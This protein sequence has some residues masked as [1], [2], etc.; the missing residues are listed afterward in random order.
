M[1]EFYGHYKHALGFANSLIVNSVTL[2]QFVP[3]SPFCLVLTGDRL[4]S[5][6]RVKIQVGFG[7]YK[8]CIW[9]YSLTNMNARPGI[10]VKKI[11]GRIVKI[12]S[13][14]KIKFSICEIRIQGKY[15]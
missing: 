4:P 13:V 1:N 5:K 15:G 11:I 9:Q 10:C 3:M 6:V 2:R 12:T 14:G 7:I 8:T